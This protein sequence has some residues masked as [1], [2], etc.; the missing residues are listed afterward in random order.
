MGKKADIT[1]EEVATIKRKTPQLIRLG[2]Q[3]GRYEFGTA[4]Q[5]EDGRWSYD[6]VFPAFCEHMRTSEKEMHLKI[7]K[8]RKK[9]ERK[10][11]VVCN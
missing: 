8:I 6:I 10:S 9:G 1:V 4:I 3:Q 2:L 11:N 7:S 5:K